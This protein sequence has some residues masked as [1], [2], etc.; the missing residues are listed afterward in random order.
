MRRGEYRGR[1]PP[2]KQSDAAISHEIALFAAH[3]LVNVGKCEGTTRHRPVGKLVWRDR[4]G[5]V[6]ELRGRAVAVA[7]AMAIAGALTACASPDGS[8]TAT[9]ASILSSPRTHQNAPDI[10]DLA[11]LKP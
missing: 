9:N 6:M 7:A 11:G 3:W 1:L 2:G 5:D 10:K 4:S 8:A